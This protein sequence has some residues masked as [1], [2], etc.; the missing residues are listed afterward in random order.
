MLLTENKIYY[1]I[2]IRNWN[3][4]HCPIPFQAF[5]SQLSFQCCNCVFN[6][7]STEND[8]V[9]IVVVVVSVFGFLFCL[10]LFRFFFPCRLV[11]IAEAYGFWYKRYQHT[12][13]TLC[14]RIDMAEPMK[15][16]IDKIRSLAVSRIAMP[17][18]FVVFFGDIFSLQKAFLLVYDATISVFFVF[19][20]FRFFFAPQFEFFVNLQTIEKEMIKSFQICSSFQEM[21]NWLT[22]SIYHES[23]GEDFEI[24]FKMVELS[25]LNYQF[26]DFQF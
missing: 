9:H 19:F 12:I 5:R 2:K 15:L 25:E 8:S 14:C 22:S 6:L 18:Q 1:L 4:R 21:I 24:I 20:F 7:H 26:F 16:R 3:A 13:H 10:D 23:K 11:D 17:K